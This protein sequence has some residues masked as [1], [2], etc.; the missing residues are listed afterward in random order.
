MAYIYRHVRLDLNQPFYIG[1]GNSH[2]YKRAYTKDSRNKYWKNIVT[3]TEY[4]VEIILD[5]LTWE[6]A[7]EK[8]IEFIT[9][10]GRKD[11]GKGS[12]VNLTNGGEG[13]ANLAKEVK[14]K[15]RAANTGQTRTQKTKDKMSAFQRGKIVSEESR[16]KMSVSTTGS[17]HSQQTKDKI[18]DALKDKSKSKEHK[19]S[20]G[21]ALK[22]NS[23]RSKEVCQYSKEGTLLA[24][25]SSHREAQIQTG[26]HAVR[27]GQCCRGN[28]KLAGGF[29]WQNKK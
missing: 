20:I 10:Y 15:I 1:I 7:C 22:G 29:V 19:E 12:L 17:T 5:G 13:T 9:L 21:K 28:S 25:Y 26:V 18:K 6:E 23:N 8:E 24:T 27:I 14:E 4:R 2:A 16:A 11:L 3:K